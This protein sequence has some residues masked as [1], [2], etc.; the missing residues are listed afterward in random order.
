MEKMNTFLRKSRYICP[1]ILLLATILQVHAV[2]YKDAYYTSTSSITTSVS[3]WSK[4]GSTT[5]WS[6]VGN[7]NSASGV[8]LGNGWVI[9]CAHVGSGTYTLGDS[10]YS[11]VSGSTKYLTYTLNGNTYTSDVC[12][13]QISGYE[14]ISLS[15]L[16]VSSTAV[17]ANTKIVSIGYGDG[18]NAKDTET[19]GTATVTGSN[20]TTTVSS[21]VS[22]DFYVIDNYNSNS[23]QV[24]SGDSGGGVFAYVNG[25][26]KLVGL[27]EAT[28]SATVNGSSETVSFFVDLSTYY[29]QI[30]SILSTSYIVPEPSTWAMLLVG[31]LMLL[32]YRRRIK[33]GIF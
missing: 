33:G 8:Y 4:W 30:E 13:F 17:T 3:N 14:N 26:W 18:T 21:Y 29:T 7:V 1:V 31:G 19:W 28:G 25:S 12:M 2:L 22:N 20:Y 15:T 5:G 24:V 27:N 9:T 11:V 23:F 6:Y 10:S 32:G 16:T